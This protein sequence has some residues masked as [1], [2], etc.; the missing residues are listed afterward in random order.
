MIVYHGS[1]AIVANPDVHHSRVRVDFGAGFYTTPLHEQAAH[2]CQRFMRRG[3]AYINVYELDDDAFKLFSL[4]RFDS[5]SEEWL[6]F[7]LTCR[8][9]LDKSSYDLVLG[10][11]ANDKVFN[12]VEL[13]IEN[14]IS[15]Q[16]ALG[17]LRYAKPNSQ[18]CIRSQAVIDDC[19]H[20][21]RSERQ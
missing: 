2:W 17:R 11:V 20:Y 13:Y 19:L 4:L 8:R 18:L 3:N 7:V 16:D 12:T 5:Y 10:G 1:P 21:V 9:G 15:K 14:L 6:D